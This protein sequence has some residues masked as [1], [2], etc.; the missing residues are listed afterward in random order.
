MLK[1]GRRVVDSLGKMPGPGSRTRKQRL[2]LHKRFEK[3]SIPPVEAEAKTGW[4]DYA[5]ERVGSFIMFIGWSFWK[6][7]RI[8]QPPLRS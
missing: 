2:R 4:G 5:L 3:G 8:S 6:Y 7:H 1:A